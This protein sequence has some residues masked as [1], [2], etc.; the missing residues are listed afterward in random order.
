[1]S[2]EFSDDFSDDFDI[3][4]LAVG[5]YELEHA[6]ANIDIAAATGFA[7]EHRSANIDLENS[8]I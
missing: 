8:G 7:A 2:G 5:Q 6:S 4:T 1:M 3:G